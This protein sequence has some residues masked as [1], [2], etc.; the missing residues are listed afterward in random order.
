MIGLLAYIS[1]SLGAEST[2][3][4]RRRLLIYAVLFAS[5]V[6][7]T[8]L[9]SALIPDLDLGTHQLFNTSPAQL[10]ANQ[11]KRWRLWIFG[12]CVPVVLIGFLDI[13]NPGL[14]LG[15]KILWVLSHLFTVAGMGLYSLYVYFSIGPISQ[16]W[17]EGKKGEW[18]D[19]IT[20]TNPA[21]RPSVPRGL[22][23]A[24]SSTTRVFG[25]AILVTMASMI[26]ERDVH[27]LLMP[28]PGLL[29]LGWSL[30][31]VRSLRNQFDR[32]Y[33]HTNAFYGE[34]LRAGSFTSEIKETTSYEGL[35]WIPPR[36]RPHTW[37]S[38]VQLERVIPI[39]RFIVIAIAFLWILS[40]RNVSI[41]T[42]TAYLLLVLVGK[43]LSILFF[44]RK[45]LAA[46][47]LTHT[48][49]S[50]IE[51]GITR[52]FVNLKWTLPLAVGLL[53]LMW[54]DSSFDWQVGLLW[55]IA[56]IMCS[57]IFALFITYGSERNA[58]A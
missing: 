46:P 36:W 17:Q 13:H 56:D 27:P 16:Q 39:G 29:M 53:P 42:L 9:P 34:V 24:L 14:D 54:L 1:I 18:W 33:Y 10:L 26:L 55:V 52:G 41:G 38:L 2:L 4:E 25:L 15:S 28:A 50:P 21:I 5:A 49:Q 32:Y 44:N 57:F 43:N 20:E 30:R 12:V 19:K 6:F 58:F 8:A 23:P 40:W 35:Y 22:L 37:A 47:L 31:R 7:A 3:D 45:D 11:I 51:W 48:M